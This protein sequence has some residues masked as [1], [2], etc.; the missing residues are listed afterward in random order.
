MGEY[1]GTVFSGVWKQLND[2][3]GGGLPAEAFAYVAARFLESLEAIDVTD[4]DDLAEDDFVEF[5][6]VDLDID[7]V[8][9]PLRTAVPEAIAT[10]AIR[11]G[12]LEHLRN[13]GRVASRIRMHS[14]EYHQRLL[15]KSPG[16]R[17]HLETDE[18]TRKRGKQ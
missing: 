4:L 10:L 2:A 14:Q 5:M 18:P 1:A 8:P 12:E 7:L 16:S 6:L 11:L 3:E 15:G 9:S 17:D 13:A